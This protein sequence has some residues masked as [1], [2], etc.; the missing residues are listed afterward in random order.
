MK[1][2][3]AAVLHAPGDLRVEQ[4]SIPVPSAGEALVRITACGVC[5]SDVPRVRTTGTYRFPTIPGH[6][7]SGI[8]EKIVPGDGR[9]EGIPLKVGTPVSVI[10]LVPCR[11]CRFCERGEFAQCENYNFLGSRCD[12]GFA[13]YLKAPI[14]N[15]VP[16]P[17]SVSA[18]DGALLE[19]IT[20]ALHAVRNLHVAWGESVAVFGLGAIGNFVAQWARVFGGSN[21]IGID[22]VKEKVDIARAVGLASSILVN[23]SDPTA[24]IKRETGGQGVDVSFEASGAE[25][26]I[27]LAISILRP[28]G[29]LGL[30]GRPSASVV[31]GVDRIEK[32]LR[33]Q[34]TIQGTWSFEF[35]RF[36]HHPWLEAVAALASQEIQASPLVTHRISL[37][38][39][40]AAIEM[41]AGGKE[42]F[43]KVVAIP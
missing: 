3:K 32:I 41:M 18:I 26:A 23:G 27:N 7:M 9:E 15:L 6:E 29:R 28:F 39:V 2:M 42:F 31:L 36:P 19:P 14:E 24:E 5:G 33:G 8:I 38:E 25:S 22:L 16:L 37:E 12:G 43:T 40:P 13:E 30:L 20:V 17:S 4:V 35:A 21:V 10:P 11:R 1:T 34:I